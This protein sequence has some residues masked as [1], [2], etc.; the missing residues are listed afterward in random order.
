MNDKLDYFIE[1]TDERLDRMENK[2]NK[3]LDFRWQLIG[4]AT[5]ISLIVSAAFAAFTL[6]FK[7]KS[8]LVLR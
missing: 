8:T 1:K 7:T 2:L 6:F 4:G 5:T 3:L